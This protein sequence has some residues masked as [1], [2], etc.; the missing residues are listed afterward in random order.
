MYSFKKRHNKD[1]ENS[2]RDENITENYK[3]LKKDFLEIC[4]LMIYFLAALNMR[5]F[6]DISE[7]A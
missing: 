4:S 1:T 2:E 5:V 7:E 3:T 6:A